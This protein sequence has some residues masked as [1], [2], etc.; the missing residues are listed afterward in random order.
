MKLRSHPIT[1]QDEWLLDVFGVQ[2]GGVALEVGGYDGI[3]HSN[4][5]VLEQMRW[6]CILIEAVPQFFDQMVLN[7]PNAVCIHAAVGRPGSELMYVNGEWSGLKRTMTRGCAEGH[8]L[9]DSEVIRVHPQRLAELNVPSYL[10][11]LSLDTEGNEDEILEDWFEA[12]GRCK[13][14]TVEFNYDTDKYYRFLH[15]CAKY[16]MKLE[17]VQGFDLFFLSR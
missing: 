4:T 11:Y 15:L 2:Q 13:A 1:R 10:D 6:R 9:R 8:K 12:G 3:T 7:R 14:L 5:W 17:R 16:G